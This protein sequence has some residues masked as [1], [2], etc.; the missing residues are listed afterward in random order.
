[1]KSMYFILMFFYSSMIVNQSEKKCFEPTKCKL[2]KN[3]TIKA[4]EFKNR[5]KLNKCLKQYEDC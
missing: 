3:V 5:M 1:M 2:K 4:L